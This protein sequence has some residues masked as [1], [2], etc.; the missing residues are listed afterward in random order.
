[1][2]TR[3]SLS[4]LYVIV[5]CIVFTVAILSLTMQYKIAKGVYTKAPENSTHKT[6]SNRGSI[7]SSDSVLL[8]TDTAA[9]LMYI[10]FEVFS[11][12]K[13]A[14]NGNTNYI[15]DFI[16]TVKKAMPDKALHRKMERNLNKQL[17][18]ENKS[19]SY[20]I[21]GNN[22]L[23]SEGTKDYIQKQSILGAMRAYKS[24]II[25]KPVTSR[26]L[27]HADLGTKVIGNHDAL[28]KAIKNSGMESI[29][30]HFLA[31]NQGS[32][33]ILR[34]PYKL[35]LAN[36]E[37]PVKQ[38]YDVTSTLNWALQTKA[39]EALE[40]LLEEEHAQFGTVVIMEVQTGKIRAMVNLQHIKSKNSYGE[41]YNYAAGYRH[42]PGSTFKTLTVEALLEHGYITD[43][44]EIV[45]TGNGTLSVR[46]KSR[47]YKD[48]HAYG[49]LNIFQILQK[50]S[51]VGIIKL[52]MK[53]YNDRAGKQKYYDY[54]L[55][56]PLFCNLD[57]FTLNGVR[58]PSKYRSPE[59]QRWNTTDLPSISIG[60]MLEMTPL[61]VV[62][63]YNGI[64]NKGIYVYP[65]L[66]EKISYLG[67]TAQVFEPRVQAK[68][69]H[70][71]TTNYI[72]HESLKLVTTPKG[73]APILYDSCFVVAGKTGT[74]DPV[75]DAKDQLMSPLTV[76][77]S[78]YFP[79]DKPAYSIVVTVAAPKKN[80]YGGT[81]A[82]P[83]VKE[84]VD[85]LRLHDERFSS[86]L[87]TVHQDSITEGHKELTI[88]G[89]LES[90][91]QAI[92]TLFPEAKNN[93]KENSNEASYCLQSDS[94]KILPYK[95]SQNLTPDVIGMGLQ[96][97]L[98]IL[99]KEGYTVEQ[100][101]FGKVVAQSIPPNSP[102]GRARLIQLQ[103]Q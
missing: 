31:G 56:S 102:R 6:T 1:M 89:E 96:D 81:V 85:F 29:F 16:Q 98:H 3:K 8:A 83:V 47:P 100:K 61:H 91:K 2:S 24:G 21:L 87:L 88:K 75:Y 77:F 57:S 37:H 86:P 34:L 41:L 92:H 69:M 53:Y 70:S 12:W 22:T 5:Q 18:R 82:A 62:A 43:G 44:Q 94:I 30:N 9:Y 93:K 38:G 90:C 101:G 28:N 65:T 25:F 68:P 40:H 55:Q 71:Q 64:A 74:T 54:L 99:E 72:L 52:A 23:L 27:T 33:E 4:K 63:Y 80:R 58:Q 10:D 73:T 15:T 26:T 60:C 97:A 45:D 103:L 48:T 84:I 42:M 49:Q 32:S 17:S 59:K 11:K 7:Y 46:G 67:E 39:H 76:S 66:I 95:P 78:G 50:S 79:A 13:T 35:N 19:R 20:E 51:N 36:M 14:D